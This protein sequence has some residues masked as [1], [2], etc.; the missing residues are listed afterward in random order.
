MKIS[1]QQ[2]NPWMTG[3][4]AGD[5]DGVWMDGRRHSWSPLTNPNQCSPTSQ[6]EGRGEPTKRER[7][8]RPRRHFQSHDRRQEGFSWVGL[9]AISAS[10]PTTP[11][12]AR[13]TTFSPF[14]SATDAPSRDGDCDKKWRRVI[15]Y[16]QVRF[17]LFYSGHSFC[18]SEEGALYRRYSSS[19][20]LAC[21]T[22]RF[23]Q[24][25][26]FFALPPLRQ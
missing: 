15:N 17:I 21:I 8:L 7:G 25:F 13:T 24:H 11:K 12:R 6:E 9:A 5:R 1:P 19:I 22:E 3:A 10:S 20:F 18:L 14:K 26:T 23:S 4:K 16:V 2:L